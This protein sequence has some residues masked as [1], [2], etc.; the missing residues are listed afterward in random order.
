ML[1]LLP[2]Y[3]LTAG[4]NVVGQNVQPRYLLP[5]IVLM[6][7]LVVLSVA[8]RAIRFNTFQLASIA[9]TLAI[10]QSVA[11]HFNIRR[12]VTGV[13]VQGWNLDAGTEWWWSG[14]PFSPMGIWVIGSA[15]FA[16]L[17]VVL[18]R[19]LRRT[20]DVLV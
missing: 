1:W 6:G 15:A 5:L 2:V 18:A 14:L 10:A 16:A 4:G 3:V 12:Y 9:L 7:G 19:E 8:G 17:A 20:D 13:D 11:L